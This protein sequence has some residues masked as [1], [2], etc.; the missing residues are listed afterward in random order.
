MPNSDLNKVASNFI[1]ITLRDKCS[2]VNLLHI[3]K[4]P[5]SKNT[6]GGLRL[7]MESL[8]YHPFKNIYLSDHFYH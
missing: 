2:P 3:F 8:I 5:F 1:E 6:F 4:T 7:S